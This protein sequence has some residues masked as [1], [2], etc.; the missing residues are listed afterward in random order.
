[1][2]RTHRATSRPCSTRAWQLGI[3]PGR[4]GRGAPPGRR[5]SSAAW[6]AAVTGRHALRPRLAS[7]RCSCTTAALPAP[8]DGGEGGPRDASWPASSRARPWAR[9]ASRWRTCSTTARACRAFVPVLR[10][11]AHRR[12]RSCST[13]PARPPS[14]PA[15]AS[16]VVQAAAAH[17]ARRPA[18]HPHRLQRRGLHPPGRDPRAAPRGAPLDVALPARTSP[19]RCGL[20]ARF[21][22]L[23]DFPADG[24]RRAH[25]RH[26]PARARPRPGEHVGRAAHAPSPARARWMTTTPG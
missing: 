8:V 1:M 19:S 14:A 17:A 26:A 21:H 25:R 13:R 12:T 2:S 16:E 6:P 3:F 11:G 4:A 10:R 22:R 7:P 23:T 24:T 9:R 5:R 15:S 18:A 20:G